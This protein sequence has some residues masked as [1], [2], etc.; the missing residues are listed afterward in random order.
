MRRKGNRSAAEK[1]MWVRSEIARN[2]GKLNALKQR[3][4]RTV[5]EALLSPTLVR[6]FPPAKEV[7]ILGGGAS[8]HAGLPKTEDM[9]KLV[10]KQVPPGLRKLINED[11]ALARCGD[12]EELLSAMRTRAWA[13][14]AFRSELPC[15]ETAIN[16]VLLAYRTV[17]VSHQRGRR[18]T[19]VTG[20]FLRQL[21]NCGKKSWAI[22]SFNQ[23]T[24]V[25]MEA[26]K[27]LQWN[28]GNGFGHIFTNDIHGMLPRRRIYK[29]HGC[30]GWYREAA[31]QH[32]ALIDT[33]WGAKLDKRF[34]EG[35]YFKKGKRVAI[36]RTWIP[37][38]LAPSFLKDYQDTVIWNTVA[39]VT[40][41][42]LHATH[43]RVIGFRLR[44]DDTLVSHLVRVAL[45]C[46]RA[47]GRRIFELIGPDAE[48]YQPGTMGWAWAPIL[49]DLASDGWKVK[50]LSD[51]FK[52]YVKK[53]M[54]SRVHR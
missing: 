11:A 25:E 37:I 24:V 52:S 5:Q 3:L 49:A 44:P 51:E 9:L 14:W 20:K 48:S 27:R 35:K 13:G 31:G 18:G 30:V 47:K 54:R 21:D 7:A 40:Y 23:D 17:I 41:E 36:K 28:E 19:E 34:F 33:L 29:P 50:R 45:H 16:E 43:V 2:P 32:S 42:L 1:D 6:K 8:R 10:L 15:E 12:L 38:V 22:I 26:K 53:K 39:R 4:R 46:N